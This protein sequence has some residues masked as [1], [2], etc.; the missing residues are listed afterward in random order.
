MLPNPPAPAELSADGETQARLQGILQAALDCIVTIDDHGR[1]IEFN[2]AAEETFGFSSAEAIGRDMVELIVPPEFRDRHRHGMRQHLE[3]G[4]SR[5]MGRR[6]DLVALRADGS[7]FPCELTITRFEVAGKPVF[8]AFIRDITERKAA[9]RRI[10]EL[11]A[12]LDLEVQRRTEELRATI[13]VLKRTQG[14]LEQAHAVA[15]LAYTEMNLDTG[16]R[17]W[18]REMYS[19]FGFPESDVPPPFAEAFGRVHPEDQPRLRDFFAQFREG[20]PPQFAD[21]RIV[22][23]GGAVRWVREISEF[24]PSPA[25][26]RGQI[27]STLYDITER[28]LAESELLA[29]IDR[30]R[31]LGQLK[32]NFLQMITHEYRTPLGV[33]TS[34]AEILERYHERLSPE[35]RQQQ[36]REIRQHA[37][38]LASLVEEVLFLGKAE[39]GA[40]ELELR[41]LPLKPF[42]QG[43]IREAVTALGAER[44]VDLT[45]ENLPER[46]PLD[47]RLL[48]H[49][50]GNLLSN[51]LKYSTLDR[52]VWVA[53]RGHG[54]RLSLRIR[55]EGI[56][57]P[58]EDRPRV[59]QTFHRASNVGTVSGSGLGLVIVKRCVDLHG[60][61]IELQSELGQGTEVVV[62]LPL[63]EPGISFSDEKTSHPGGGGR[64]EHARQPGDDPENGG[65]RG[66]RGSGRTRR[67]AGGTSASS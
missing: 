16:E 13:A 59:F 55:D 9:E 36:L 18:S 64:A 66:D 46:L 12:N 6:V 7:E 27:D 48:R 51:A 65:L 50:L 31:Q 11:N 40:I 53:A 23:P 15:R 49:I 1:I 38:H 67:R 22:L 41:A 45:I 33:I 34:S 8:T 25:G 52:T 2:R 58:L 32:T 21:Y 43:L 54:D 39:A 10:Q 56:G 44:N 47:E 37:L 14:K 4:A 63:R 42:L 17:A 26:G 30:E 57:I 20:V 28:K 19:I 35:E 3:T 62:T 29:A 61:T 5:M 24:K 60:G